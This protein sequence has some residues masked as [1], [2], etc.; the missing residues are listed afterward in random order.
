M[1]H[2]VY[3]CLMEAGPK[4]VKEAC[5][6]WIFQM[7]WGRYRGW[8][9]SASEKRVFRPVL[10]TAPAGRDRRYLGEG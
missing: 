5:A 3:D 2:T 8:A 4:G 9:F 10:N 1:F 7:E 6:E